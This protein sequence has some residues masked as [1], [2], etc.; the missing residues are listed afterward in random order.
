MLFLGKTRKIVRVTACHLRVTGQFWHYQ[1]GHLAI[2]KRSLVI[3]KGS[4]RNQK[5][6]L[7]IK[8]VTLYIEG[9][10]CHYRVSAGLKI[11]ILPFSLCYLKSSLK[12]HIAE[13]SRF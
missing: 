9:T 3:I 13:S 2:S 7:D 8:G 5:G 1:N 6:H 4:L 11:G 12:D 10:A